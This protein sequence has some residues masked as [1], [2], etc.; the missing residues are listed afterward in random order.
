M[1]LKPKRVSRLR[2]GQQGCFFWLG[3][4]QIQNVSQ[5]LR[6]K[7]RIQKTHLLFQPKACSNSCAPFIQVLWRK[8]LSYKLLYVSSQQSLFLH[9]QLKTSALSLK[10]PF[11]FFKRTSNFCSSHSGIPVRILIHVHLL[12][13]FP[14][15][16]TSTLQ[17][18]PC[19]V[20]LLPLCNFILSLPRC[21]LCLQQSTLLPISPVHPMTSYPLHQLLIFFLKF[22]YPPFPPLIIA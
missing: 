4:T 18:L 19:A 3:P 9:S 1:Q 16:Y 2:E 13:G 17:A 15:H 21:C 12:S 22:S 6:L 20:L 14:R 7:R 8:N 10:R 5:S 11:C